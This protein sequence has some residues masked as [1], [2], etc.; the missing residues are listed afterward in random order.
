MDCGYASLQVFA[1]AFNR[2]KLKMLAAA[3]DPNLGGRDVDRM[4][5]D[6]FS[7]EFQK[8]YHIDAKTN[9]RY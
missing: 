2:G 7:A 6:H 9:A 8:K 4:L 1:C 3:S 5:A